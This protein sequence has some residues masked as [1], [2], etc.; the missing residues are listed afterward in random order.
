MKLYIYSSLFYSICLLHSF[1]HADKCDWPCGPHDAGGTHF[2]ESEKTIKSSN[3]SQLYVKWFKGGIAVLASPSIV[4]GKI[5]YG[6]AQGVM[7][8]AKTEDGAEIWDSKIGTKSLICSPT[9]SDD[10]IYSACH[11]GSANG[12]QEISH[13]LEVKR[14]SG[15]IG[16]KAYAEG[17]DSIPLFEHAP[18]Y[19]K[20]LIILG[21]SSKEALEDKKDY[22]F[23]GGVYAFDE[24]T[25]FLKWR[26]KFTDINAGEGAGVDACSSA[27]LDPSLGYLYIATGNSYE[28]PASDRS[29]ALLCLHYLTEKRDGEFIWGYQFEKKGLWSTKHPKGTYWGVKG[30]PLLFKSSSKRLVGISDN[31]RNFQAFDRKTGQPVWSTSLIP[32]K[33]VPLPIGSSSAACDGD[34]IYTTANYASGSHF[35]IELFT[36]PLTEEKQKSLLKFL[37]R[38]CK[39]TITAIKAKTGAIKWQKSFDG[40]NLACVSVANNIV[41][42]AFFN[43][44]LRALDAKSGETLFEF[45]TGPAPGMYGLPPYNLSIPLNT[46]PIISNGRVFVGGGYLFPQTLDKAISGG[47]FAFELPKT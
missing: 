4:G 32:K 19:D 28:E 12:N 23:Q 18:I 42:A 17:G 21:T 26:Y 46:T 45:R 39:S 38:Q 20:H 14:K 27:S 22:E 30:A 15:R 5:Y 34:I 8:A 44:Y 1:V 13:L 25:G 43:G 41:Y 40:A 10:C 7:H 29:C 47:L 33:E 3:V 11:V 24:K 36:K 37:S 35:S 6:D 16:W 31:Q 9:I 2:Q